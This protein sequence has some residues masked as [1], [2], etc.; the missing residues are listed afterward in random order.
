MSNSHETEYV[1]VQCIDHRF[2]EFLIEWYAKNLP[3]AYDLISWAGSTKDLKSVLAQITICVQLHGVSYVV[4]IH[5][6][7]CGAYGGEQNF[8]RA[9]HQEALRTA[10]QRILSQHPQLQI[11]LYYVTLD[12][13]FHLVA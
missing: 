8:S 4:L 7:D 5:H 10:R 11:A 9:Q 1:V 2:R 13:V 6:Q 12:G 3:P